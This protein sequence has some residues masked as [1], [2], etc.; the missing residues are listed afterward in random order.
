MWTLFLSYFM[1]SFLQQS[2]VKSHTYSGSLRLT[3]DDKAVLQMPIRCSPEVKWDQ[4]GGHRPLS[5]KRTSVLFS[6]FSPRLGIQQVKRPRYSIPVLNH[7]WQM[8]TF[9]LTTGKS[10]MGPC[11]AHQGYL[12]LYRMNLGTRP[13]LHCGNTGYPASKCASRVQKLPSRLSFGGMDGNHG[14]LCSYDCLGSWQ[15]PLL[16]RERWWMTGA[17]K[18][19]SVHLPLPRTLSWAL[20]WLSWPL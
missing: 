11:P 14:I 7:T 17:S 8:G 6:V 5:L 15:I 3:Q 13:Q 16:S 20:F 18:L 4:G 2:R 19:S 10:L 1:T 12:P 9:T